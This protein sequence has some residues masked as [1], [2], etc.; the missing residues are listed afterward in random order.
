MRRRA[1]F[2][3]VASRAM[4][5]LLQVIVSLPTVVFTVLVGVSLVYWVSVMLGAIDLEVSGTAEGGH[6]GHEGHEGAQ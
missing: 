5:R 1:D 3:V 4:T 2:A 6:E